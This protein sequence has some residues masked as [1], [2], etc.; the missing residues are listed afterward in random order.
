MFPDVS[1]WIFG[2]TKFPPRILFFSLDFLL[3]SAWTNPTC[4]HKSRRWNA[5][6][7]VGCSSGWQFSGQSGR[8]SWVSLFRIP[9]RRVQG[10]C[11]QVIALP[12]LLPVLF[13]WRQLSLSWG[14]QEMYNH[15]HVSASETLLTRWGSSGC[16]SRAGDSQLLLSMFLPRRS[17]HCCCSL[18][19]SPVKPKQSLQRD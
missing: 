11:Q 15:H 8:H 17:H 9:L 16:S 19:D 13:A 7:A 12:A 3:P 1:L 18:R 5:C 14:K 6:A 2:F 10:L 4:L